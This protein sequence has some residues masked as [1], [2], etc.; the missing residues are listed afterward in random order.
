MIGRYYRVVLVVF[1][2]AAATIAMWDIARTSELEHFKTESRT[3]AVGVAGR[4]EAHI[5]TRLNV[6]DGLKQ[7]MEAGEIEELGDM[8][9]RIEKILRTFPDIQALNWINPEGVI[10]FVYPFEPNQGALGLDV[11]KL[12]APAKALAQAEQLNGAQM[13]P[14]FSLAQGGLGFVMYL[15]V[16]TD[17]ELKGYLNVVFRSEVFFKTAVA[18]AIPSSHFIGVY[19]GDAEVVESTIPAEAIDEAAKVSFEIFG[20]DWSVRILPAFEYVAQKRSNTGLLI[21]AVGASLSLLMGWMV[22]VLFKARDQVLETKERF[23]E[24]AVAGSDHLWEMNSRQVITLYSKDGIN[25]NGRDAE[26]LVGKSL[27]EYLGICETTEEQRSDIQALI[28]AHEPLREIEISR[29]SE[30]HGRIWV[31]ISGN[32]VFGKRNEFVGYAGITR[33]ITQRKNTEEMLERETKHRLH[34]AQVKEQQAQRVAAEFERQNEAIKKLYESVKDISALANSVEDVSRKVRED[35]ALGQEVGCAAA[36]S[37][38]Q[39]AKAGQR[40][41]Q[42]VEAIDAIAFQTNLLSL[43]AKVEAARAGNAGRGFSVVAGEV[44]ALSMRAAKVTEDVKISLELGTK[45]TESG[46]STVDDA[47]KALMNISTSIDQASSMMSELADKVNLQVE[48]IAKVSETSARI[49]EQ[50]QKVSFLDSGK[51]A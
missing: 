40:I 23:R 4:L 34:V 28:D 8:Q 51:A 50:M 46:R 45:Q 49:D 14:P 31:S 20:R 2:V 29:V 48:A 26:G 9:G 21:L 18:E 5:Q 19:D 13:T 39:V 36:A 3:M 44:Q 38:D 16:I 6:V 42:S 33:D 32:P 1:V 27:I 25:N 7:D 15:P 11:S 43:N 41:V 24:F 17:G 35:A 22:Y 47:T 30:N 10:S 37:M 12:E